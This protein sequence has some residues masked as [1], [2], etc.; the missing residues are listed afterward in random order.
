MYGINGL[1][2]NA[3]HGMLGWGMSHGTAKLLVTLIN[4]QTNQ[5]ENKLLKLLS[6]DVKYIW[7]WICG[8]YSY[9]ASIGTLIFVTSD[10][11][12]I[13]ASIGLWIFRHQLMHQ[14]F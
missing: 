3:G 8:R 9:P 14:F 12:L 13:F 5:K 4:N 7:E 1:Y 2:V 6:L 11:T 10:A